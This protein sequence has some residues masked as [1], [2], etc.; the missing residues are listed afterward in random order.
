MIQPKLRI[1]VVDDDLDNVQSIATA[2]KSMG[3]DARYAITGGAA[4]DV[5]KRYKPNVVVLDLALPDMRG[6]DLARQLRT[7]PGLER[8]TFVAVSGSSSDQSRQRALDAGCAQ[9]YS[10]PLVPKALEDLLNNAAS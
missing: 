7:E 1:L 10:K 5:A 4:V 3:H 9:V 2:I 8:T 6:D